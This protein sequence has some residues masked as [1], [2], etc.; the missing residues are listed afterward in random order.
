MKIIR[1]LLNMI[2]K[3]NLKLSKN[4]TNKRLYSDSRL[5]ERPGQKSKLITG[6]MKETFENNQIRVEFKT[7]RMVEQGI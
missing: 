7:T 3:N 6:V 5:T 4:I 1:S 2:C